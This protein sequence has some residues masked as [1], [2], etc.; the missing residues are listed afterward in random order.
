MTSTL[1]GFLVEEA[2]QVPGLTHY[3][4]RKGVNQSNLRQKV[5]QPQSIVG[6]F[7]GLPGKA[8]CATVRARCAQTRNPTQCIIKTGGPLCLLPVLPPILSM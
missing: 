1:P 3:H 2:I 7:G 8:D 4:T 6:N 5:V